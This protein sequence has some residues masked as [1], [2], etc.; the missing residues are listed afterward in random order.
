VEHTTIDLLMELAAETVV[1]HT[2]LRRIQSVTA[3]RSLGPG[4]RA[5]LDTVVSA[6]GRTSSR[7]REELLR[8]RL[9]PVSS[10]FVRFRRYVRDL[11]RDRG[12]PIQLS[13]EGADTT[14]DRAVL[15]R[16]H[17]PLMHLVRNAVAHG[18]ERPEERASRGKPAEANLL[19]AA[20]LISGR[21]RIAVVDDGR[22]LNLEAISR[23]GEAIGV[24]TEGLGQDELRRLIFIPGLSTAANV[25]NLAGRGV[26]LDVVA[27]VVHGL[28]GSIDV[29]SVPGEGTAFLL[30]LPATV[31]QLKALLVSI[32]GEQ[33]AVPLGFLLESVRLEPGICTR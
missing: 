33:Y 30:N 29:E 7:L 4:D 13:V 16:L 6:L 1:S 12:Q 31:S 3:R 23:Q 10:L 21:V 5:A 19:L 18:L 17:E 15:S 14:V 24:R 22:G 2:E 28:G 9:M 27:D 8:L 20:K 26:G 25:T 32:D 11:A